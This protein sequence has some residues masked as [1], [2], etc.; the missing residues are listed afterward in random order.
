MKCSFLRKQGQHPDKSGQTMN[1]IMK[2]WITL[3]LVLFSIHLFAQDIFAYRKSIR[4]H[5]NQYKYEFL[6]NPK[7]PLDHA[8]VKKLRFFKAD[9]AFKV[10]C[11]FERTPD[12]VPFEMPTYS[13]DEK[14]F[15][16]YG[17]ITFEL[18][19]DTFQ[20]AI[21]RNMRSL[22]LPQ[23]QNSL[24]LPFKDLTNDVDSYGGGRY[25]NL[26]IKNIRRN[27]LVLDFNKAYNPYC[28]YGDGWNCPIPPEENHLDLAIEAGEKDFTATLKN[29]ANNKA[30]AR[31]VTKKQED[32]PRIWTEKP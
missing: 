2:A 13:G 23:F 28:A 29:K 17:Y 1:D 24:F 19:G 16:K 11:T 6:S 31:K 15:V 12:E 7:S 27:R 14:E 10:V 32:R 30:A 9:T 25:L 4:K 8:G 21:Y 26:S 18:Q 5:R 3:T 22:R 20:L